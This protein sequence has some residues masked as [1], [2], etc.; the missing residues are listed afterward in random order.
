MHLY[1]GETLDLYKTINI[2]Y[3]GITVV[4]RHTNCASQL[5]ILSITVYYNKTNE[6]YLNQL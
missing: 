2:Q 1:I 5:L 6:L 4:H 3:T